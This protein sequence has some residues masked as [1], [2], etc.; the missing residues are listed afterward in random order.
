M[1]PNIHPLSEYLRRRES[2]QLCADKLALPMIWCDDA[3]DIR[4]WLAG[5]AGFHDT[6]PARCQ[7]CYANRLEK[8]AECAQQKG[9][10]H[11][12]SSLCY[13]RYQDHSRIQKAGNKAAQAHKVQF[14]YEDFSDE[15]QKG[16]DV[17]KEFGLYRQ[18]Y[19]GCI[20]SEAE[21]YAKKLKKLVQ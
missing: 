3:W 19:C 20:Y 1:N 17:S 8:C 13:S 15:W 4:T 5:V 7:W 2:M 11:F 21:R 18:A 16:V 10:A 6:T 14:M 9:F 12:T